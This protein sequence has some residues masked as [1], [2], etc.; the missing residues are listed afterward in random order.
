MFFFESL[1]NWWKIEWY[2]FRINFSNAQMLTCK[3][4][5]YIDIHIYAAQ[6]VAHAHVNVRWNFFIIQ[7]EGPNRMC[8]VK[9]AFQAFSPFLSLS[10]THT[11]THTHTHIHTHIP[12]STP[13]L[14]LTPPLYWLHT[15]GTLIFITAFFHLFQPV[16]CRAADN[17]NYS[18]VQL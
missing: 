12:I 7:S 4:L 8:V 2:T 11:H 5:G 17:N 9:M 10:L 16:F 1:I 14:L 18:L 15:V 6:F 13:L 3:F